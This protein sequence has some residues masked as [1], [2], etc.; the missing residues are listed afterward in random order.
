MAAGGQGATPG[1]DA[2]P[3]LETLVAAVRSKD[4]GA[5]VIVTE[6]GR[7]LGRALG[8]LI[9]ALDIHQIVL[10]GPMT[11]FGEPWLAA[12]REEAGRSALSLLA[13]RTQIQI[14]RVGADL[15]ERGAAALLMSS[16]LGLSLAA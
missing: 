8:A 12:V 6:A 11:R 4:P 2:G 15:V 3:D 9:G 10:I 1:I 16:E 5:L 14:G 7:H 13:D